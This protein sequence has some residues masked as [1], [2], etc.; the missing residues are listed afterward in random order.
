MSDYI[1]HGD[2]S[3]PLDAAIYWLKYLFVWSFQT[4]APNLDGIIRLPGRLINLLFFQL[5]G[6]VPAAYFYLA[7]TIVVCFVAFFCFSRYFLKIKNAISCSVIALLFACNP[8]FLGNMAKVGLILAVAML[9]LCLWMVQRT[10]E[11]ERP[12][13]LLV[14]AMLL[15]VSLIHPFTFTINVLVVGGYALGMAFKHRDFI[16]ERRSALL[17]VVGLA[18]LMNVYFILPIAQLG[19][20]N[21]EAISQDITTEPV[22]YTALIDIANTGDIVTAL[23]LSKNVLK[24]FEFFDQTYA[25]VYFAA[26]FAI[27]G[28]LLGLY[29]YHERDFSR[30]SKIKIV[31]FLGAFLLLALLSTGTLFHIDA[32]IKWLIDLPGGWIFRSPLKWQLY[33]PLFLCAALVMVMARTTQQR[34]RLGAQIAIVVLVLG[35]N[36]YIIHD[37]YQKLLVPRH[38]GQLS[39]LAQTDLSYKTILFV[40]SPECSDYAQKNPDLFTELNQIVI[41]RNVQLKRVS[42][43]QLG[44]VHMADYDFALSCQS[45]SQTQ[46]AR[47][48]AFTRTEAFAGNALEL[49]K[50]QSPNKHVFAFDQ[51]FALATLRNINVKHNF[52]A[53]QLH[54]PL[55]FVEEDKSSQP[56]TGIY[57]IFE[58][59]STKNIK[60]GALTVNLV[61]T[62]SDQQSL[63]VRNDQPLYYRVSEQKIDVSTSPLTGYQTL[64]PGTQNHIAVKTEARKTLQLTYQNP[65]FDFKNLIPNPSLEEGL[66]QKQVG[67]CNRY[68]DAPKISMSSSRD[69]ATDGQRSLQLEAERHIACTGPQALPVEEGAQYLLS[70]DYQS[71]GTKPA[72]FN[73]SFNDEEGQAVSERLADN[74]SSWQH[75]AK[76]IEVPKG[77]DEMTLT[78]YAFA[79]ALTHHKNTARYDNFNLIKVPALQDNMYLVSQ[80]PHELKAPEDIDYRIVNPTEKLIHIRGATTPFYI[81]INETYHEQWRLAVDGGTSLPSAAHFK[82]N[83]GVNGWYIDPAAICAHGGCQKNQDGSYDI[84]LRATFAPQNWLVIGL[85]I[86]TPAWLGAIGYIGYDWFKHKYRSRNFL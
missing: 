29:L 12:S 19:T 54:T 61:P 35:M 13:Y 51:L 73:V 1:S 38:I 9:P 63:Y 83:N 34:L 49:Y 80:A 69:T 33:M 3:L 23:S 78:L 8:I 56:A 71:S 62:G 7:S 43:D 55:R 81:G 22:D 59:L 86:S 20:V 4:G 76:V 28:I 27:Y 26:V 39:A 53:D 60:D 11:K 18:L 16:R 58:G 48:A 10:F 42:I 72:G 32:V 36:G 74:A 64:E 85:A 68:D 15:N 77:A 40:T 44:S 46:L 66:W 17:G 82:L 25:A 30:R 37:I 14:A 79:D 57:D 84:A 45:E 6:S 65:T 24:D 5:F 2:F 31:L 70:F 67:D 50:N 75:F 52:V 47:N 41:S 21:K